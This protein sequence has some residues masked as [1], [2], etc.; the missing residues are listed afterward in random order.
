[1]KH[2]KRWCTKIF[3]VLEQTGKLRA[4]AYLRRHNWDQ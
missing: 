2:I 1:M 3:E 4:E